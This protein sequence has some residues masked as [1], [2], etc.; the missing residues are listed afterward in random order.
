MT[1]TY[2]GVLFRCPPYADGTSYLWPEKTLDQ[3][4]RQYSKSSHLLRLVISLRDWTS[5]RVLFCDFWRQNGIEKIA[6]RMAPVWT[7]RWKQINRLRMRAEILEV[8]SHG[9][10][11]WRNLI[12]G[13]NS[14]IYWCTSRDSPSWP[15]GRAGTSIPKLMIRSKKSIVSVFFNS[16][17][18]LAV[19]LLPDRAW[20]DSAP[21]LIISFQRSTVKWQK[22]GQRC[23]VKA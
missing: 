20:F 10:K 23:D 15:E 21:W 16:R 13:D 8:L 22:D 14:W 3:V 4:C 6:I 1:E 19:K 11:K 17:G 2:R 18:F 5:P 12:T 9:L 7:F